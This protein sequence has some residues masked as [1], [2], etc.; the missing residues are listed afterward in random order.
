MLIRYDKLCNLRMWFFFR[1]HLLHVIYSSTFLSWFL[2]GHDWLIA[3]LQAF[4]FVSHLTLLFNYTYWQHRF[5]MFQWIW[6]YRDWQDIAWLLKTIFVVK[7]LFLNPTFLIYYQYELILWIK[8]RWSIKQQLNMNIVHYL[9]FSNWV[10]EY[11]LYCRI[12]RTF[13]YLPR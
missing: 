10:S 7:V 6:E 11:S 9:P 4:L 5:C 13:K 12:W 8:I 3:N 1:D 2:I